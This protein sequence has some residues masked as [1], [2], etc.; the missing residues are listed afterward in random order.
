MVVRT[1]RRPS[2]YLGPDYPQELLQRRYAVTRDEM[3]WRR[4]DSSKTLDDPEAVRYAL[5]TLRLI[6]EAPE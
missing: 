2:V 5:N 6:R 3:L 4:Y 1:R